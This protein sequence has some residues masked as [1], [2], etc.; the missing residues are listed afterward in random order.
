MPSLV[1]WVE[2]I[3]IKFN[4][5]NSFRPKLL[6]DFNFFFFL[7]SYL[8]N[9]KYMQWNELWISFKENQMLVTSVSIFYI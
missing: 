9:K 5:H 1:P 3:G 7:S 2:L 8:E 4:V 6:S